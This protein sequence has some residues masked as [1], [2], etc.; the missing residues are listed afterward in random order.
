MSEANDG[1]IVLPNRSGFLCLPPFIHRFA[2]MIYT[3]P[4]DDM[5]HFVLM[6][7]TLRVICRFAATVGGQVRFAHGE[8]ALCVRGEIL[9][10]FG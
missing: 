8:I 4:R 3:L 7:Y 5:Q 1:G 10:P 2:L 9:P 6:I